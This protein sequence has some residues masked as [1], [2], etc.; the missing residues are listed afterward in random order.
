MSEVDVVTHLA[1]VE[2]VMQSRP[3]YLGDDVEEDRQDGRI[4]L[5]EAVRTFDPDRGAQFSTYAYLRIWRAIQNGRLR[6]HGVNYR[7]A[8]HRGELS[9]HRTASLDAPIG[10]DDD[11]SPITLGDLVASEPPAPEDD[12]TP[13]LDAVLELLTER[14]RIAVLAPIDVAVDDLGITKASVRQCRVRA[15][16]RVRRVMEEAR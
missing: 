15:Y 13:L 1:L 11:G 7:R 14:E 5:L 6:R 10:T 8:V 4:G 16:R 3:A 12:T 9:G 2:F